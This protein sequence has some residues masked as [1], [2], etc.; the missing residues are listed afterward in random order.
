MVKNYDKCQMINIII[1]SIDDT[2]YVITLNIMKLVRFQDYVQ[3]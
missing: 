1:F 2:Y 3:Y